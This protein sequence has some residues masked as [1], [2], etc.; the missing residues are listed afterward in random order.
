LVAAAVGVGAA[1]PPLHAAVSPR[2][3]KLLA[4]STVLPNRVRRDLRFR[5]TTLAPQGPVNN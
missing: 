4:A 2:V 5:R 3:S 1:A